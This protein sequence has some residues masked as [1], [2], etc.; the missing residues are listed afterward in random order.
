MELCSEPQHTANTPRTTEAFLLCAT[1]RS[2]K[3]MGGGGDGR[4]PVTQKQSR[5]SALQSGQKKRVLQTRE[6]INFK[7]NPERR[8]GLI[9]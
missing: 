3:S 1:G 4:G 8:E 6:E 5:S 2:G 7:I 9:K